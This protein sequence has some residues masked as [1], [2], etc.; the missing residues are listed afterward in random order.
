MMLTL[1]RLY[2]GSTTDIT[3]ECAVNNREWMKVI[4]FNHT[5]AR[6]PS[7]YPRGLLYLS[8]FFISSPLFGLGWWQGNCFVGRLPLKNQTT[9]GDIYTYYCRCGVRVSCIKF[10]TSLFVCVVLRNPITGSFSLP[11][12]K[13]FILRFPS[14]TEGMLVL[15]LYSKISCLSYGER[16]RVGSFISNFSHSFA[17]LLIGLLHLLRSTNCLLGMLQL[18]YPIKHTNASGAIL[19]SCHARNWKSS[20]CIC[21]SLCG[22]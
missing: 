13:L 3:F 4:H 8:T 10:N 16:Q 14:K 20:F 15:Y 1:R 11:T 6:P 9:E 12:F 19:E 18:K 7:H 5:T 17:C 21:V 22:V 2:F